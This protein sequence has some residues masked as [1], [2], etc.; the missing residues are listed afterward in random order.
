MFVNLVMQQRRLAQRIYECC[1]LCVVTQVIKDTM[2]RAELFKARKA[3]FYGVL[4]AHSLLLQ[5]ALLL[6]QYTP[7]GPIVVSQST[8][9]CDGQRF[10]YF[11][12]L[13]NSFH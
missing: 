13:F 10:L 4:D 11:F 3:R 6:G 12:I 8:D 1:S 2:P 5:G 7:A 9:S